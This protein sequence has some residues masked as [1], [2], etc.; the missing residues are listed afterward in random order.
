MLVKT[1]AGL[2]GTTLL[3]SGPLPATTT[4]SAGASATGGARCSSVSA[5]YPLLKRDVDGDGRPDA[6]RVGVAKPHK[7]RVIVGLHGGGELR[8]I[9]RG[10]FVQVLGAHSV[11]GRPGAEIVVADSVVGNRN[12]STMRSRVLHYRKGRLVLQP[13]PTGGRQWTT[14][15]RPLVMSGWTTHGGA[16]SVT[17][18]TVRR[19]G[20]GRYVGTAV[21]FRRHAGGWWRIGSRELSFDGR[22]AAKRIVGWRMPGVQH[23]IG[24]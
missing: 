1:L 24:C 17:H 20:S 19:T 15:A 18:R 6:I 21:R 10:S 12:G 3:V 16:G 14:H 2:A 22:R 4:A 9:V 11:D 8:R 13:A 5:S 23:W 7:I